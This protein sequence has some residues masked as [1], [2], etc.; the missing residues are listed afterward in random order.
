MCLVRKY[1]AVYSLYKRLTYSKPSHI[2]LFIGKNFILP[3]HNQT[4]ALQSTIAGTVY[5]RRT[6]YEVV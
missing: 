5:Q 2:A 4:D 3:Q 6:A 1:F